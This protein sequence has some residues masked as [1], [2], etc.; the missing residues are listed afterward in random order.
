MHLS[1][2]DYHLPD[3]LIA[4]TPIEPRDHSNLLTLDP[5]SGDIQTSKFH[6]IIDELTPNDVL[7]LNTTQ[8]IHA[9]LKGN[10]VWSGREVEIFLHKQLSPT[11]W[12]CMV[13]PGKK[14][15][16]WAEVTFKVPPLLQ[17]RGLGGEVSQLT[18]K[19]TNT[20]HYGKIVEFNQS[21]QQ[22]LDSIEQIGEIPLPPYIKE[23]LENTDRYQTVFHDTP[24]SCAAPTASLHFTPELLQKI[25]DKWIQIEYVLLHVGLGTFLWVETDDV[26]EH[27]MHSE[28][29]ELKE[30]TAKKLNQAKQANKR[31]I[32]VGTTAVR[33]LESLSDE[34]WVIHAGARETDIFIYPSYSWKFVDALITNFHLPKS[35]LLMLVSSFGWVEHIKKAYQYAIEKSFRFFS[36]W[37]AMFIRK[38]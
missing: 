34:N 10:K 21:W 35:T 4:Q 31:I 26:T 17:E 14:L 8:V 33:V 23:S 38:K 3:S 24:G 11:T 9:R 22:F 18:A 7:V 6:N 1:D 36:F 27:E 28:Y 32:A 12:D 5:E 29:I 25:Q 30:A 19:I 20:S 2:F 13:F 16:P 37:D 15:K